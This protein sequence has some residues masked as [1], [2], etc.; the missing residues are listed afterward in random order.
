M[1]QACELRVMIKPH[2]NPLRGG[3]PN[4]EWIKLDL[5]NSNLGSRESSSINPHLI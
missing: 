1:N 2:E 4:N 3:K 5:F